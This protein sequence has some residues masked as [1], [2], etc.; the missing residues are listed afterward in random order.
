MIAHA[1][2]IVRNELEAHLKT[3]GGNSP[4]AELGNVGEVAGS[5]ANGSAAREGCSCR[6]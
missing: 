4:H 3:F 6:S 1:L 5:S 2:T